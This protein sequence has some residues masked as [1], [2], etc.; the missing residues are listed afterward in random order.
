MSGLQQSIQEIVNQQNSKIIKSDDLSSYNI[1]LSNRFLFTVDE[2]GRYHSYN[3]KPA[4]VYMDSDIKIWMEHGKI[5][6]KIEA[7]MNYYYNGKA[8]I[9][10]RINYNYFKGFK[11]TNNDSINEYSCLYCKTK[12]ENKYILYRN[13]NIKKIYCKQCDTLINYN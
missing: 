4:I 9:Y 10:N 6:N 12:Y 7:S 2:E 13:Y 11:Y 8:T 5:D 3:G 1:D